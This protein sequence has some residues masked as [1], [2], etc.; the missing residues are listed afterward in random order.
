MGLFDLFKRKP[1]PV[2]P[3]E[4]PSLILLLDEWFE[5]DSDAIGEKLS[6]IEPLRIEPKLKIEQ[7][8]PREKDARAMLGEA[9]FDSHVV[10]M[11]GFAAPLPDEVQQKTVDVSAWKG[12]VLQRLKAHQAHVMLFHETGGKDPTERFVALYKLA[13]VMGGDK[14]AGVAIEPAW[15]CASAEAVRDFTDAER[16]KLMREGVPPILFL[17]MLPFQEGE[18]T[19]VATKGAHLWGVPDLAMERGEMTNT[20]IFE[21]LHQIFLYMKEGAVVAPGHTMQRDK[22]LYLKFSA[23]PED[24]KY[25]D[26][27]KGE[28]RTLLVERISEDEING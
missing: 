9:E 1:K 14:A 16:L 3:E 18:E 13:S 2:E 8:K 25:V 24:H 11:V 27:L 15:T 17:G 22:D 26:W 10:R 19:W 23:L 5:F 12:P 28:G 21:L 4:R 6:A 20:E 7:G